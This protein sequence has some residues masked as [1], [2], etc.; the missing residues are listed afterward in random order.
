MCVCARAENSLRNESDCY[1]SSLFQLAVG[2]E[3]LRFWNTEVWLDQ[4]IFFFFLKPTWLFRIYL[5]Q[6]HRRQALVLP[7]FSLNVKLHGYFVLV[8]CAC[9]FIIKCRCAY[10]GKSSILLLSRFSFMSVSLKQTHTFDVNVERWSTARFLC[11]Q[12]QVRRPLWS[13]LVGNDCRNCTV[14]F[15]YSSKCSL[16]GKKIYKYINIYEYINCADCKWL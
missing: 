6:V 1:L 12:P 9:V 7:L 11:F 14:I 8:F 10:T 2:G 3:G 16:I 5:L 4:M 13:S 15:L